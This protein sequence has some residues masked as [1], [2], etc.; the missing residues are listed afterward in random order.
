MVTF[1]G[2]NQL[3]V[4]L[5]G[6]RLLLNGLCFSFTSGLWLPRSCV[7]DVIS[8]EEIRNCWLNGLAIKYDL[9]IFYPS[10][11]TF[12]VILTFLKS[13]LRTTTMDCHSRTGHIYSRIL[14]QRILA[15]VGFRSRRIFW[16][17]LCDAENHACCAR[18]VRSEVP[19][20]SL[21]AKWRGRV[22]R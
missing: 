16:P 7:G 5:C 6:S 3:F 10:N 11:K 15:G 2:L 22:D 19:R 21:R 14:P 12:V 17:R 20:Q 18:C 13:N 8:V 1:N 9:G 4:Q